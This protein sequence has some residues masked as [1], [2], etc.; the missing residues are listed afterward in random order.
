MFLK[1]TFSVW[2]AT[3]KLTCSGS[4]SVIWPA[5]A[6]VIPPLDHAKCSLLFMSMTHPLRDV[7]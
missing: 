4:S 7:H 5:W 3:V 1:E 6:D 2:T